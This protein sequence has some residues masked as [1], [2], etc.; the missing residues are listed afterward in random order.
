M[1]HHMCIVEQPKRTPSPPA[2]LVDVHASLLSPSDEETLLPFPGTQ[3]P[4][5]LNVFSSCNSLRG[6]SEKKVLRK[7]IER[8]IGL[9]EALAIADGDYNVMSSLL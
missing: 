1:S 8:A 2:I 9:M 4:L 5:C 7:P 6:H 3:C